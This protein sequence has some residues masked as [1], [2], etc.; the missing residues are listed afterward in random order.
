M[1]KIT[2]KLRKAATNKKTGE[3]PV[4]LVYRYGPS[5]F[6][7]ATGVSC[8]PQDFNTGAGKVKASDSLA[9]ERNARIAQVTKEVELVAR[10][11]YRK[12]GS[13]DAKTVKYHLDTSRAVDVAVDAALPEIREEITVDIEGVRKRIAQLEAELAAERELLDTLLW[14]NN[15]EEQSAPVDSFTARIDEFLSRKGA[16]VTPTT[17]RNYRGLQKL[18]TAFRPRLDITQVSLA[19][20]NEFQNWLIEVKRCKNQS[21]N[22]YTTQFKAVLKE[23]A[24][25]LN[26][27]LSFLLK[28]KPVADKAN[29]NI[30]ILSAPEL[31]DMKAL[32]LSKWEVMREVREQ[33]L[34]CHET[35]LRHSDLPR[36]RQSSIEEMPAGDGRL[37][38]HKLLRLATQKK[39]KQIIV[40]LTSEALEIL[41][42][43]NHQFPAIKLRNYNQALESIARRCP[44]L[45]AEFVRTHY[46]GN[47]SSEEIKPKCEFVQ[48]HAARRTFI[49]NALLRGVSE[50]TVARWVGHADVK[51]IQNYYSQRD[52]QALNEAHKIL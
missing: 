43:N 46:S 52:M 15:E 17:A 8:K 6:V 10:R 49:N 27:N 36:V 19:T 47:R 37:V 16:T 35:G 14:L 3:A 39:G 18:I 11:A 28:F 26:I 7:T 32:D 42:R 9:A 25:E 13:Y 12:N 23:F 30:V 4:S 40:P 51:M 21:I 31:A 20:L 22:A 34:F 38:G 50:S 41:A 24:D 44:S 33:F 45:Q 48:S 2:F 5:E 1:Y 29:E